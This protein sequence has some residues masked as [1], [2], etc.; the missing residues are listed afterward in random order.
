[1]SLIEIPAGTHVF[2]DANVLTYYFL[3]SQPFVEV[4]DAF[5]ERIASRDLRAFTSADAAA[6]V[7][8]RVM[9]SEAIARFELEPRAAVSHLK[10]HPEIVQQLVHFRS[11]PGDLARARIHILDVTYR[12]LHASKQYREEYGL[13]TRD[14]IILAVMRR[15][16]LVH[17][18]TNDRDFEQ[19]AGIKVWLPR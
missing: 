9:V 15:N 18:A 19:I 10:T 5:F 4:C 8:H 12:E 13:L 11:I 1:M 7:I 3:Q 6:D 14:S 2:V 16:K 17:M